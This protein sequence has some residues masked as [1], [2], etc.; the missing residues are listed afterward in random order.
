[1]EIPASDAA[2]SRD[3]AQNTQEKPDAELTTALLGMILG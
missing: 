3:A 2:N 1:M